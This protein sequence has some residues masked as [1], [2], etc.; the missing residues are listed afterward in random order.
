MLA[1]WLFGIYLSNFSSYGAAYGTF[2]AAIA[3]LLW[4]YI[5]ANAFLFGAELNKALERAAA[6]PPTAR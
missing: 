2:G 5:A 6:A 3:L 4:L 1:S